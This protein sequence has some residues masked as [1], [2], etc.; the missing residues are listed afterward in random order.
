MRIG[1]LGAGTIGS[2]LGGRL[3]AAGHDVVLVGR[4]RVL[5]CIAKDGLVLEDLDGSRREAL[6]RCASDPGALRDCEVVLI[7]TKVAD[8]EEAAA[9]ILRHASIAIGLQNGVEAPRIL[10]QVLGAPRARAGIVSWNAVWRDERTLRRSTSGPVVIEQ[11]GEDAIVLRVLAALDRAG[12]PAKGADPIEPVL[13]SK[14]LFNLNNAVNAISGVSLADELAQR[15]W[16]RVVSA[17]QREGLDALREAGISPVR[18]GGTMDPRFASRMLLVPDVIF[19]ALAGRV[20]KIDAAARSSMA[21][22]LARGRKT[23]IAYLQGAIVELGEKVG[24]PTPV[25]RRVVEAIR[26]MERGEPAGVTAE[27]LLAS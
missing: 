11:R 18:L 15:G 1:I 16:R 17:C 25:N 5:D 22:D 2:Y 19:R 10:R 8:L 7:T 14:L 23:E 26:R 12:I 13:W 27:Q 4:P 3:S 24:V 6:P 21:D 20:V 9:S